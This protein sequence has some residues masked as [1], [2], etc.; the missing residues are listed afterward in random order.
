[1]LGWI[2]RARQYLLLVSNECM[3][4]ILIIISTTHHPADALSYRLPTRFGEYQGHDV[5]DE[6]FACPLYSQ[7]EDDGS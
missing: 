2:W 4:V 5:G 1:M 3:I 6:V 7:Q